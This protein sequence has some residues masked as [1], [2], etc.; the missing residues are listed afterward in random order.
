MLTVDSPSPEIIHA[1]ICPFPHSQFAQ[2]G[3]LGFVKGVKFQLLPQ[4]LRKIEIQVRKFL[5]KTEIQG[6]LF[7]RKTEI[8]ETYFDGKQKSRKTI[9]TENRN[10]GQQGEGEGKL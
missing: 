2:S 5:Q 10:P 6:Q 4:F 3:T 1:Q 8:Q 7:I 9:S